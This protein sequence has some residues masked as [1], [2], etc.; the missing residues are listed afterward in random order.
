MMEK[1]VDDVVDCDGQMKFGG[2]KGR[3]SCNGM[4]ALS[5]VGVSSY[6]V[7]TQHLYP[8]LFNFFAIRIVYGALHD[9]SIKD[10]TNTFWS[11]R[12]HNLIRF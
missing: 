4:P 10:L 8:A 5:A 11:P 7:L 12:D 6:P 1:K 9:V 3:T 2:D